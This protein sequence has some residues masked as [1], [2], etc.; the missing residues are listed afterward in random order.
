MSLIFNCIHLLTALVK[1]YF[2]PCV[3]SALIHSFY[4]LT[5]KYH[6]PGDHFVQN[7]EALQHFETRF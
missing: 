4:V 7:G 3:D 1:K 2:F 6:L 5:A